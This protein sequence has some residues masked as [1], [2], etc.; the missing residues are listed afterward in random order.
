MDQNS[1]FSTAGSSSGSTDV[2]AILT[3]LARRQAR[4]EDG[5]AQIVQLLESQQI[6]KEWYSTAEVAEIMG[7][8]QY[9]VQ[10]RWCNQGRIQCMK[11]DNGKWRI[12]GSEVRRLRRGEGL[13]PAN[14]D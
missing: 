6:E 4:I 3:E 1:L 12:P 2:V 10:E 14:D 11:D 7:V 9:T 5:V 8:K 13:A